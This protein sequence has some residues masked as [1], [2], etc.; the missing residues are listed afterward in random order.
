VSNFKLKENISAY[1]ADDC[2]GVWD[3][4]VDPNMINAGLLSWRFDNRSNYGTGNL[5]SWLH[6]IANWNGNHENPSAA[7]DYVEDNW[8]KIEELFPWI[9][10]VRDSIQEVIPYKIRMHRAWFNGHT[11]GLG[12]G[13]HSDT[14]G[15]EDMFYKFP[16]LTIV[17]F[18]NKYWEPS[19]DGD[20]KLYNENGEVMTA[21]SPQPG[22]VVAFDPRLQHKGE[23]PNRFCTDLRMTLAWHSVIVG[24]MKE[25]KD[26]NG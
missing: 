14:S 22:R 16:G 10:S 5:V 12:D 18:V 20:I 8:D 7:A 26:K 3:N 21:V 6:S 17:A 23:S 2:C 25:V 19:W 13:I 24:G 1:T 15:D 4:V 11:Y 9:N